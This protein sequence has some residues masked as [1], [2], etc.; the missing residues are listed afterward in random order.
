MVSKIRIPCLNSAERYSHSNNRR[1][2]A[3]RARQSDCQE[4]MAIGNVWELCGQE[5]PA[6][7]QI[8]GLIHSASFYILIHPVM[9]RNAG[10]TPHLSLQPQGVN[11][12]NIRM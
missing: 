10:M 11:S 12:G 3:I 9:P 6:N 5:L 8:Y 1:L 4:C 7:K 2:L